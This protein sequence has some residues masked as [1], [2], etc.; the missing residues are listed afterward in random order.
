M[1]TQTFETHVHRPV[2]TGLGYLFVAVALVSLALRWFEIGGRLTFAIGLLATIGAV[3]ALLMMSRSYTTKLQDRIIRMEM[4]MRCAPLLTADQQRLFAGLSMK[5][6]A[7]LR[8][9]SDPE[10][11]ALLER[12]AREHLKPADVKRAIKSWTPDLDRT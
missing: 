6:I 9:A 12:T 3:I 2:L 7:A 5:Q 10:L 11:P 8:F 4:R 1:A